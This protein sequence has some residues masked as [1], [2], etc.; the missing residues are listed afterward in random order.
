MAS[1]DN[2]LSQLP[3]DGLPAGGLVLS[4]ALRNPDRMFCLGRFV[5][6]SGAALWFGQCRRIGDICVGRWIWMFWTGP[7]GF[8]GEQGWESGMS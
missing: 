2:T 6:R 7:A 4:C 5:D 8:G 3:T 1:T